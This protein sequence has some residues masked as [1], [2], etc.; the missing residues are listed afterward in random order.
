MTP[1]GESVVHLVRHGEVYNPEG[2]IYGRLPGYRLSDAGQA[3]ARAT[4]EWLRGRDIAVV[5]S[6]PLERAVQTA[7]AIAD[8]LGLSV[9][10]DDRLIESGSRFEGRRVQGPLDVLSPRLLPLMLNPFRPSWGEAYSS[11]AGRMRAAA[12]DARVAAGGREAV[13]VSHQQPIW[14][15]RRS[16]EAKPLW[17]R[18]DRRECAL[19]SVTTVRYDDAGRPL[20]VSYAEPAGSVGRRTG[21]PPTTAR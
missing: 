4:A 20:G 9:E 18:P 13:C 12:D 16:F 19:A 15:A 7:T 8:A 17:H 2:I 6:S 21:R 11:I 10:T 5:R 3:M 14:V 1:A